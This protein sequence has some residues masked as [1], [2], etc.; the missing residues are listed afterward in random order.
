VQITM[1]NSGKHIKIAFQ[2]LKI[3]CQILKKVIHRNS[4]MINLEVIPAYITEIQTG[5]FM[6]V[7]SWK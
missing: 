4:L 2:N 1:D 7:L 3:L 6:K 5:I